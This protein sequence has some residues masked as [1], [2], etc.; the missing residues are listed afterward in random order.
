MSGT[1]ID[2]EEL[3]ARWSVSKSYLNKLR[4]TGD[5]PPFVKI[6]TAVRYDLASVSSWLDKKQRTSTS[7]AA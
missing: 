5:G 6:G 4:L 2:T 1:L 7:Q 3:A